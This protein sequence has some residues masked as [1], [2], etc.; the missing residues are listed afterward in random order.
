MVYR[1]SFAGFELNAGSALAG[2]FPASAKAAALG[3]AAVLAAIFVSGVTNGDWP[4]LIDLPLGMIGLGAALI[5]MTIISTV[6]CAFYVALIGAP[7][8][9][10]MGPRLGS[11]TGLIVAIIAA[12]SAGFIALAAVGAWP[13]ADGIL[14]WQVVTMTVVY[15]LPAGI[16]YRRDVLSARTLSRWSTAEV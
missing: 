4:D 7:L 16:F 8:A 5:F 15:A 3:S 9:W 2:I 10:L 14:A 12:L 6:F 13:F 11:A 1:S